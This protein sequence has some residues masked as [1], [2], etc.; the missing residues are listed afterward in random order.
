[1]TKHPVIGEQ[2]L[3]KPVPPEAFTQFSARPVRSLEEFGMVVAIRSAVFLAEQGCPYEEEFD[4]NDFCASHFL[5]F[6]GRRAV[7]TLRLRWFAGFAKLERV[8]MLPSHRNGCL[9]LK[10]L[11]AE[12]FEVVARKGYRRIIA[13][14]QARLWG[15]WSHTFA[16]RLVEGRRPFSFSDYDYAE[17][18]IALPVHPNVIGARADPYVIIRPEGEWDVPGV[19]DK[20]AGRSG[21]G[22]VAA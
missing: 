9:A 18:E 13:Q 4:G 20:S 11:L 22:E 7:G 16:C 12:A 2:G 15:M 10:V 1:M 3:F 6:E 14:I 8:S 17:V 21:S 19:L 5:V